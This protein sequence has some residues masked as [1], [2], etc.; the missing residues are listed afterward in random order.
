MLHG[1]APVD[2]LAKPA[3]SSRTQRVLFVPAISQ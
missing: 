1:Q 3:V 2:V